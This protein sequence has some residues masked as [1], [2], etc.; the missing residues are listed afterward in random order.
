MSKT[1]SPSVRGPPAVGGRS[2]ATSTWR[3]AFCPAPRWTSVGGWI[4]S[5][6]SFIAVAQDDRDG[7]DQEDNGQQDDDGR[8]GQLAEVG[9]GVL[10]PD[11]DRHG[12]RGELRGELVEEAARVGEEAGGGAH[13][14]QGGG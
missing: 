3:G 8:G 7:V 5:P 12:E 11:E 6:L 14:D 10:G 13:Q 1:I 2:T 4:T 9:V